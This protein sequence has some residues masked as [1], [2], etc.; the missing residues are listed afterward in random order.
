M[1]AYGNGIS[2]RA[3]LIKSW[4]GTSWIHWAMFARRLCTSVLRWSTLRHT[5]SSHVLLTYA[6]LS[7]SKQ[8]TVHSRRRLLNFGRSDLGHVAIAHRSPGACRRIASSTY[9]HRWRSNW[10]DCPALATDTQVNIAADAISQISWPRRFV[11]AAAVRG[12]GH[13]SSP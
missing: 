11:S 5:G 3:W 1:S 9:R 7:A 13:R 10:P 2:S 8:L 12:L 4:S 6:F